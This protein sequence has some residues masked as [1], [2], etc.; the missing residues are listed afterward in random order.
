[1]LT[2]ACRI[3]TTAMLPLPISLVSVEGLSEY[4][5]YFLLRNGLHGL[6]HIFLPV[7]LAPLSL[8]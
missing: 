2:Y 4:F 8:T 3:S 5:F 7:L 6:V 1:M